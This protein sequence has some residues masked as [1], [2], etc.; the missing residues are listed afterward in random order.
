M[1]VTAIE[2]T[3]GATLLA[4]AAQPV[5]GALP[6]VG[7]GEVATTGDGFFASFASPTQAVRCALDAAEAVE[8]LGLRIRAGVHTGEVEVRGDDLGGLAVH[9]AARVSGAGC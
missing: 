4:T 9:I 8:A 6:E 5:V 3:L 2:T 7:A 1:V